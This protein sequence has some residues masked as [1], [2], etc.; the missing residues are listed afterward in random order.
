M[1]RRPPRSTLFPYTTLF[2]SPEAARPGVEDFYQR[3][4]AADQVGLVGEHLDRRAGPGRQL[5]FGEGREARR[6]KD[7]DDTQDPR[8]PRANGCLHGSLLR[9][10]PPAHW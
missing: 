2:R 10:R 1:I 9:Q 6:K 8:G 5:R 4:A 7:E 3:V